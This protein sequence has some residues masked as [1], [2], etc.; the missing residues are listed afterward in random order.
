MNNAIFMFEL[1]VEMRIAQA[2]AGRWLVFEHPVG[3]TSWSLPCMERLRGVVDAH[4]VNF[5]MCQF[6]MT[7][8]GDSESC[9]QGG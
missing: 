9:Q 8:D 7:L 4:E 2:K 3:A 5:D 1:A 6:G